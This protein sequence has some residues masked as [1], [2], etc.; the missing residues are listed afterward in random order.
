MA[1]TLGLLLCLGAGTGG[2]PA[3]L[4]AVAPCLPCHHQPGSDPVGEW[5]IS[6]YSQ[7][8]GGRGCPDCH[9]PRCSGNSNARNRSG[10]PAEPPGSLREAARLTVA[11][12]CSGDAV[13]AEVVVTNLGAGHDLPTGPAERRLV[14][15]V[16]AHGRNGVP[17]L[18]QAGSGGSPGRVFVKRLPDSLSRAYRSRLAPFETDVSRYRFVLSGP[19][20]AQVTARLA[21]VT[22]SGTPFEIAS[23]TTPCRFP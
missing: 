8:E 7:A 11:A 10:A 15:D 3:P 14:L 9:E 5:L 20:T 13:E 22:A 18:P 12:T 6:P 1:A 23:T 21:L 4:E 16:T 17:L 19:G 2:T